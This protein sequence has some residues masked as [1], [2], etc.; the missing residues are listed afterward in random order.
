MPLLIPASK[1]ANIIVSGI[2]NEKSIIEF[3]FLTAIGSKL[4]RIIPDF[5]FDKL[6]DMAK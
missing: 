3:P 6:A 5:I 2:E 4:L 1:A